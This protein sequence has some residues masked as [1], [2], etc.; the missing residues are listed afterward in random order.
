MVHLQDAPAIP[1]CV[2]K[3]F[4]A[5]RDRKHESL[6]ALLDPDCQPGE[7]STLFQ[8]LT[9]K[10]FKTKL[11][12]SELK[13]GER[14][15][16]C[17]SIQSHLD[18]E[19][20]EFWFWLR[21]E[22][23]G[24]LRIYGVHSE[25]RYSREWL[26]QTPKQGLGE[27]PLSAANTLFDAMQNGQELL[28]ES[29]ASDL[30]WRKAG[31]DLENLF[32]TARTTGMGFV[33]EKPTQRKN[34]ALIHFGLE[35]D[36]KRAAQ[37]TLFLEKR[38]AGW[39]ATGLGD[40]P[41]HAQDFLGGKAAATIWP[42]SPFDAT[43]GFFEAFEVGQTV[44]LAA[45]SESGYWQDSGGQSHWRR[46]A[47]LRQKPQN[48]RDSVSVE[49]DRAIARIDFVGQSSRI[50]RS[51]YC[52]WRETSVGWRMVGTTVDESEAQAFLLDTPVESE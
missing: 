34:R 28:A 39:L 36:G 18:P 25:R 40:D 24:A 12:A 26:F 52:L 27:T 13:N 32:Q 11:I 23:G 43:Q 15:I 30:A 9:E 20:A 29:Y 42:K 41:Q 4:A 44:R 49:A 5:A 38:G 45:L 50:E 37:A 7:L 22:N 2:N 48:E 14:A 1:D 33:A 17:V 8:L 10:P 16:A 3:F 21:T 19:G 51:E 31:G 47:K 35:L 6:P 46:L